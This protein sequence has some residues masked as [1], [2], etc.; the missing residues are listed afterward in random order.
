MDDEKDDLPETKRARYVA[1]ALLVASFAAPALCASAGKPEV[2]PYI[3]GIMLF[4]AGGFAVK[5]ELDR[6]HRRVDGKA[7]R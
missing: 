5:V 1:L 7:D 4:A 3:F 2:A 6:L